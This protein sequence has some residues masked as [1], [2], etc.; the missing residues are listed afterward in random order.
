M[1]YFRKYL[2]YK[3]K[4]LKLKQLGGIGDYDKVPQFGFTFDFSDDDDD[5]SVKQPI[6]TNFYIY[7]TGLAEWGTLLTANSWTHF[8]REALLRN[9]PQNFNNIIIN[10]YDPLDSLYPEYTKPAI[11]T[12][13]NDEIVTS[14]NNL[15]TGARRITSTFFPHDLDIHQVQ[16]TR[17]HIVLDM[18]HIFK[19]RPNKQIYIVPS[20]IYTDINS[21]YPGYSGNIEQG[22]IARG[23]FIKVDNLGNVTTYIDKIYQYD[24]QLDSGYQQAKVKELTD[25]PQPFSDHPNLLIEYIYEKI[26]RMVADEFRH[27]YKT[28]GDNFDQFIRQH[29]QEIYNH[30]IRLIM[31]EAAYTID[32]ISDQIYTG[33]ILPKLQ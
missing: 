5:V 17:P 27:K 23:D 8:I 30:I 12:K 19:Y 16:H 21:V 33:Y 7:T 4:Y 10:H 6:L 29:K 13:F 32:T 9:I 24:L 20:T 25:N 31:G 18:A 3:N 2:K 15:T 1:S 14:D 22:G 11:I 26:E 28:A